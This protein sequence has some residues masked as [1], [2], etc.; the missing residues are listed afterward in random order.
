MAKNLAGKTYEVLTAD[1]DRWIFESTFDVRSAALEHAEELL[2]NGGHDGVRVTAE[3]ERTGELEILFE[4][5]HDRQKVITLVPVEDAPLCQD[6]VDFYGF[7]ARRTAGKLLRNLLDDQGLTA[8]ELAF[9]PGQLMMFERNDKLFPPAMQRIGGIQAKAAGSKPM[10]R[11]DALYA[12]FAQIKERAKNPPNA[13]KYAALLA[14]KGL[15]ALIDGATQWEKSELERRCAILGA[16]AGGLASGGSWNGKL[17]ILISWT[18]DNPHDQAL[19][20]V[21]EIAAEILDGAQGV[22]E[23]LVGQPDA[24]TANHRLIQLSRGNVQPPR[25][26]VTCIVELNDM[27]GRLELPLSRQVLLERVASG[28]SGIRA[29]TREGGDF[30]KDAFVGLIRELA[31]EDGLAGGPGMCDAVIKRARMTLK[32]TDSDLTFEQGIDHLLDIMPN[33]AVRLGFLLDLAA[34]PAGRKEPAMV[35]KAVD[36]IVQQLGCMATLIPDASGHETLVRV[37]G[38]LKRRLNVDLLPEADKDS[39]IK[40]LDEVLGRKRGKGKGAGK[41]NIP[42][43]GM[44]DGTLNMND[45]TGE[46]K[47]VAGGEMIF[48]EGDIGDMAYLVISGEVEI[49]RKSGNKE[50]VL[51]TLGRGEII[52]EMSLVDNAPRMAAARAM[53]DCQFSLITRASLQQR[54]DKL[55]GN[56]RVLRRLISVLVSRIRGQAESPE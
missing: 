1:G 31:D 14:T 21:D 15:N 17:Q 18:H 29:F 5:R 8:L 39:L 10:E 20:L 6:L 42:K 4:E 9:D 7:E 19:E 13:E 51:A 36:R 16:L 47:S 56:D 40:T 26:P 25:K 52:G 49:F 41:G 22:M 53:S 45:Q 54:L 33:R 50:R 28:I 27:I 35:G 48:E 55:E 12:A 3:S 43:Y 23:V 11:I 24:A 2:G 46:R 30:E 44:K 32:S 34:S 38:K 37:V